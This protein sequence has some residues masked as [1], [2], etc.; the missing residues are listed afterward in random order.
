MDR[1]LNLL[2]VTIRYLGNHTWRWWLKPP[3]QFDHIARHTDNGI[4]W[5]LRIV[6]LTIT[7]Y[8]ACTC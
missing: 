5:Y 2:G 8:K 6:C 7:R 3:V 4:E 1:H